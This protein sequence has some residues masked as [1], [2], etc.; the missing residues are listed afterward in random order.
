EGEDTLPNGVIYSASGTFADSLL[1]VRGG[2]EN[3]QINSDYKSYVEDQNY[4]L[5]AQ[6][7]WTLGG[8]TLTSIS[9]WR[10]W[11]NDQ[12]QDGDRL[13]ALPVT[14]FHDVGNVD[15]SQLSQELRIASP[16]GGFFEYVAGAYYFYGKSEET[17]QRLSV[18]DSVADRGRADYS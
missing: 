14:A 7:D 1:P 2:K 6:L 3:R 15:Y 17:Y 9:G 8:H 5:S 10:E 12:Y 11:R 13:A 18:N 16:T 4:G